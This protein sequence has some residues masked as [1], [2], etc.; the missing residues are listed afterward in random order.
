MQPR[1]EKRSELESAALEVF[2]APDKTESRFRIHVALD[3]Q[4]TSQRLRSAEEHTCFG[5]CMNLADALEY[6]IP[7]RSTEVGWCSQTSDGILFGVRVVDHDVGGIISL[8][9]GCKVL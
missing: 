6:H 9:L 2:L 5:R 4:C 1:E 8:D 7:V 3:M